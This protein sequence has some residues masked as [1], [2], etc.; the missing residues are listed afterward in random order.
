MPQPSPIDCLVIF[1]FIVVVVVVVVVEFDV[2]LFGALSTQNTQIQQSL[3]Q[4]F[5]GLLLLLS[6]MLV[7]V[8]FRT[9]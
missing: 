7:I 3:L 6:F 4:A 5:F 1:A 8:C 9:K 2:I